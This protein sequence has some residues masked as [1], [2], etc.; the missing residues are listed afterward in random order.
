VTV[1]IT[2]ISITIV[3]IITFF[4]RSE[5]SISAVIGSTTTSWIGSTIITGLGIT[6]IISSW[7]GCCITEIICNGSIRCIFTDD[8][9]RLCSTS[10]CNT[11]STIISYLSIIC[12][13][14][15][16][17][18]SITRLFSSRF[19]LCTETICYSFSTTIFTSYCSRLRSSTT[20][21]VT[22]S[23]CSELSTVTRTCRIFDIT[24]CSYGISCSLTYPSAISTTCIF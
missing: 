6:A 4:G 11:T 7:L 5:N 14:R 23:K 8:A 2:A 21:L 13:S 18:L 17:C 19:F 3:S 10:A 20:G 9:S 1:T 15:R 22:G 24:F 12:R 16:T